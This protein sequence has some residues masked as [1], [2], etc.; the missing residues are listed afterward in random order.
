MLRKPHGMPVLLVL[1][2]ILL[3]SGCTADPG[4]GLRD[5]G[6]DNAAAPTAA[7]T[8]LLEEAVERREAI[9]NTTTEIVWSDTF[10]PGETY[11]GTAY[12]VSNQ[13]DDGN[14]GL[15][16]ETA[17]ATLDRVNQ[18]SLEYG[19]AVFFERGGTWRNTT[20]ETKEGVTYSAYGEGAKPRICA[21]PENGGDSA[22]WSLWWEGEN[23]EKIWLYHRDMPDCGAMV[24]NE[25]IIAQ[26]VLG[27]WSGKEFLH[28][29][30]PANWTAEDFDLE[31]QLS[32]APFDVTTELTAACWTICLS[33]LPETK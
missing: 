14:D 27:Y 9:V 16:P 7:A 1:A 30:G 11:T 17:W 29:T 10:T 23:G 19:D 24:L 2:V 5:E 22:L 13:G 21:S 3:L 15:S 18:A 32:Q 31:E 8:A 28:Y 12:Y 20:V 33:A 6:G 26:K 4:V 25:E